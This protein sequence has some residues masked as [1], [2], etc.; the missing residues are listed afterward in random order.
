M[1]NTTQQLRALGPEWISLA[2]L[3]IDRWLALVLG[4]IPE[5]FEHNNRWRS[6]DQLHFM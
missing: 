1:Y 4:Y 3:A 5:W 2:K 6:S